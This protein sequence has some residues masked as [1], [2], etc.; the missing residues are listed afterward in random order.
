MDAESAMYALED[1]L[2]GFEA[3]GCMTVRILSDLADNAAAQSAVHAEAAR[4]G[5]SRADGRAAHSL[6]NA[7]DLHWGRAAMFETVR[8]TC[9]PIV[10]HRAT[11]DSTIGGEGGK[12]EQ[13][14]VANPS[15]WLNLGI[16][17]TCCYSY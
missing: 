15:Q 16:S 5:D 7:A 2:G 10:P 12:E 4:I 9:S 13:A 1:I 3:V 14:K 17:E 6:D 8:L 11:K